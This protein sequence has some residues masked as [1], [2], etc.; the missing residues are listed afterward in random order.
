MN[1][2]VRE[3]F[4]RVWAMPP[5]YVERLI[6]QF[7]AIPQAALDAAIQ[8]RIAAG[9]AQ[10]FD[11]LQGND[12]AEKP[13]RAPVR[14]GVAHIPISGPIL[15]NV[16]S[17]FDMFG[18]QATSTETVREMLAAAVEDPKVRSIVLDVDSPGGTVDGVAELAGDVR[19]A[20]DLKHVHTHASDLMASAAYWIGSQAGSV[21]IGPTAAVGS[22]GVYSVM[23]DTSAVSEKKGVK[24]HVIASHP[25]KGAGVDGAPISGPQ[26]DDAQ[27]VVDSYA[28]LFTRA[29]AEGRGIPAKDAAAV[30]TGQV[31]IG[32]D[33]AGLG[34]ADHV[35]TSIETHRNAANAMQLF[36]LSAM[37][38]IRLS[39]TAATAASQEIAMSK[40]AQAELEQL[41][42]ENAKLKAKADADAA[43]AE[44]RKAD[45]VKALVARH[46][47]RVPPAASA[48]VEAL[49]ASMSTSEA[50]AYLEALPKIT[51][52]VPA[53]ALLDRGITDATLSGI[54]SM[55]DRDLFTKDPV[56]GQAGADQVARILGTT[57]EAIDRYSDV[58]CGY[59]NGTFKLRDGRIVAAADLKKMKGAA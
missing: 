41:R 49:L 13:P 37:R 55:T 24:V 25:L 21:T 57:V 5:E 47:D 20:R 45:D 26:L 30:S 8:Q 40:E 32:A 12:K 42:A 18:I 11:N 28:A 22:I 46:A 48:K 27:R 50:T 53:A 44:A 38:H 43:I 33:A 2:L 16:P 36:H 39:T 14:D 51:R 56:G 58:V 34:L 4:G 35:G 17:I 29:V 9:T 59:S 19:A 52:D 10:A 23:E 15:K 31:W 6:A 54:A 7:A 1:D 3:C